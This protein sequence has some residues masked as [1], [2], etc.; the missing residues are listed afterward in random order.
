MMLANTKLH[1]D[2][3]KGSYSYGQSV[4]HLSVRSTCR[5]LSMA[6][7]CDSLQYW[8]LLNF[9]GPESDI[10]SWEGLVEC[11]VMAFTLGI[12]PRSSGDFDRV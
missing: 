9:F 3:F 6:Q 7:R 12:S 10:S 2:P 5:C 8:V 4:F 11:E 1:G